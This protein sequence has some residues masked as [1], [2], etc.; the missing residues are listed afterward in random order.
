MRRAGVRA[1]RFM[2]LWLRRDGHGPV[3][4]TDGYLFTRQ[5]AVLQRAGVPLLSSLSALQ[6]QLSSPSLRRVLRGVHQD[7]LEGKTLSQAL[8]RYPRIFNPVYIGLIRV[9]EASGLLESV[10]QQLARLIEWEI[11]LRRRLME[12]LLY[13]AIVIFFLSVAMVIMVT[14]VI[15]RFAEMFRSFRLQLPWP[16]RLLILVSDLGTRYG[17][18]LLLGLVA[19]V[20]GL[21][22][23]GRT[24][25]GRLRWH[26]QQLR[27]PIFGPLLLEVAMARFAR[28]TAALNRSGVPMLETLTLAG[29][30]VNNVY[31]EQRVQAVAD[32]IRGGTS[33]ASAVGTEPVF[34]AIVTQMI[35]TGEETGQVDELLQH[36]AE[37]YDQQVSS[38]LKQLLTYLEPVL[39]VVVGLGVL[40]L[41]VAVY[42][43]MWD[44]VRLFK[45]PH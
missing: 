42:L 40:G 10:L 1:Q 45:Q 30:S 21:R 44:M 14:F 43:P 25:A 35:A 15:P 28:V 13:P 9:G 24:D 33:L 17:W 11:E 26:T 22:S 19:L 31:V 4:P 37:Y 34:P 2:P 7:L 12:A 23:Y 27:L 16:T 41:A 38:T 36:V 5:L 3:T 32:R 39:I 29:E 20:V 6:R 8:A 18:V